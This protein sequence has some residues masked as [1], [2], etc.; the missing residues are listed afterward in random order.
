MF[1]DVVYVAYNQL[2]E[3]DELELALICRP[4]D[5]AVDGD[6]IQFQFRITRPK[7]EL[8]Q[9]HMIAI[10]YQSKNAC[11]VKISVCLFNKS[12][13][14]SPTKHKVVDDFLSFIWNTPLA[15]GVS[16]SH[17][18]GKCFFVLLLPG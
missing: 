1:L 2:L 3:I 15:A 4:S 6:Q 8:F 7:H 5:D 11:C 13:L 16:D 17:L 14:T 9:N 10:V 18:S 12:Q